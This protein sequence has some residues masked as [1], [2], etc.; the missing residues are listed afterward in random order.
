MFS[1]SVLS[2]HCVCVSCPAHV[3]LCAVHVLIYLRTPC[4]QVR[5]KWCVTVSPVCCCPMCSI[6]SSACCHHHHRR[7]VLLAREEVVYP[8]I[9]LFVR[10]RHEFLSLSLSAFANRT[11]LYRISLITSLLALPCGFLSHSVGLLPSSQAG[12][13]HFLRLSTILINMCF[14]SLPLSPSIQLL[15]HCHFLFLS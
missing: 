15:Q 8:P 1:K 9:V 11:C 5:D 13:A 3:C 4:L 6:L 10:H 7:P 12:S 2:R 14:S